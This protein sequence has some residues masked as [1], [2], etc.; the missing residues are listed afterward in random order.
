VQCG[1]IPAALHVRRK[2][3]EYPIVVLIYCA[4]PIVVLIY[5]LRC[6]VGRASGAHLGLLL[7]G[8][9]FTSFFHGFGME[10]VESV[11]FGVSA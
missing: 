2:I 7:L 4:Y 8:V 1:R 3:G 6:H 10:F 5:C 9:G 11:C